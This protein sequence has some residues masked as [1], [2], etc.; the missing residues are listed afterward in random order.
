MIER[1]SFRDL[2][3]HALGKRCKVSRP[4]AACGRRR[5]RVARRER[6][7]TR[8]PRSANAGRQT[9]PA[10]SSKN[11]PHRG[12]PFES[13]PSGLSLRGSVLVLKNRCG[14]I[15]EHVVR[16]GVPSGSLI[17][18][19]RRTSRCSVGAAS[20]TDATAQ[21][22]T[23]SERQEVHPVYP[24]TSNAARSHQHQIVHDQRNRQALMH[25]NHSRHRLRRERHEGLHLKHAGDGASSAA[26]N[27]PRA[28]GPLR[29]LPRRAPAPTGSSVGASGSCERAASRWFINS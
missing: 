20:M 8:R 13:S 15:G 18:V 14:R 12:R 24:I 9:R 25:R 27:G 2:E 11:K 19:P 7:P 6:S 22:S 16:N 23:L 10:R 17:Q 26:S 29:G 5:V 4:R 3:N 28:R 21:R 1:H